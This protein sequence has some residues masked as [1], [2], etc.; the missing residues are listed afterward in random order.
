MPIDVRFYLVDVFA[1]EPFT[2]NP[3]A[4]VAQAERLDEDVMKLV[5]R[6][7]NQ[8]ETTFLLPP[9]RA[10]ATWR[11]RCFT[12]HGRRGLRRGAQRTRRLVVARER[13]PP[14]A[15]RRSRTVRAAAG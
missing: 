13:R 7:F 12:P 10:G 11:L 4:L 8:S 6:E 3:L 9:T 14:R 2:G 15:R 1:E 5:A